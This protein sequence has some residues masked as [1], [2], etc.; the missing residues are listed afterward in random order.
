MN[1]IAIYYSIIESHKKMG[2]I[3]LAIWL[4]WI[5]YKI[6]RKTTRNH[7]KTETPDTKSVSISISA[8]MDYV[9]PFPIDFDNQV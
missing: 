7:S 3:M 1:F 2:Y 9:I 4:S 5:E 8:G 6:R